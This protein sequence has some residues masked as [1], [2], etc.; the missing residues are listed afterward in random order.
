MSDVSKPSGDYQPDADVIQVMTMK[1]R[2]G[3]EF[4]VVATRA[5]QRLVIGVGGE[6]GFGRMLFSSAPIDLSAHVLPANIPLPN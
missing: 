6:G 1:I 5:T 3:R 4:L 2:K